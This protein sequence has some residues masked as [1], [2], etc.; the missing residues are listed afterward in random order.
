M[1]E[2]LEEQEKHEEEEEEEEV[3]W[4]GVR[5]LMDALSPVFEEGCN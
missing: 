5:I 4:A 2:P 3:G 1:E